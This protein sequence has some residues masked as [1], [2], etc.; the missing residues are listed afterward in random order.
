MKT[1]VNSALIEMVQTR[2]FKNNILSTAQSPPPTTTSTR[3]KKFELVVEKEYMQKITDA[4]VTVIKG[5]PLTKL[6][7]SAVVKVIS[8]D[9]FQLSLSGPIERKVE[10]LIKIVVAQCKLLNELKE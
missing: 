2:I 3:T 7:N 10:K 8:S 1:I 9:H 5:E 4:I 6:V